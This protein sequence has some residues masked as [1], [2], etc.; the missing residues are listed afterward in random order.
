MSER[1]KVVLAYSGGLD[2]SVMLHWLKYD[3][4]YDVVCMTADVGQ[5][6]ELSGLHEKAMKS[7][8]VGLHVLDLRETFVRDYVFP[9]LMANAVYEGYYLLGTAL[10]RPPALSTAEHW[11]AAADLRYAADSHGEAAHTRK[12][13]CSTRQI[14]Y[15]LP[16]FG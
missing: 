8:A 13:F 7:G 4:G 1:K 11:A 16:P 3:Q 10:A 12:Q 5:G 15:P 14:R 2:T 9:S 6:E